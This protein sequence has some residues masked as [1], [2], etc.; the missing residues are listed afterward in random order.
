MVTKTNKN[1][2]NYCDANNYNCDA[3]SYDCDVLLEWTI[4]LDTSSRTLFVRMWGCVSTARRTSS[5]IITSD[6][7]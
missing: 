3:T 4:S 2:N 1:G 5:Y 7:Y 6:C